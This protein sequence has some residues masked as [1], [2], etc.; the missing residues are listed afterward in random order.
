MPSARRAAIKK[1]IESLQYRV[2]YAEAVFN[3]L[4]VSGHQR[5]NVL[6]LEHEI[7]AIADKIVIVLESQSA[8]CELGA[9]AHPQLRKKLIVINDSNFRT[10]DSFV[11]TGP[12]AAMAEVKAPVLWYPMTSDG[13]TLLD[14]IGSTFND[15]KAAIFQRPAGGSARV[16]ENVSDLSATKASLYFVHD[17]VLF[18][19]PVKYDELITVLIAMFGKKPYDML[20]KLLGVLRSA[21]LV[22]VSEDIDKTRIYK[23]RS[24]QPYLNYNVDIRALTAAFRTYHLKHNANRFAN[25]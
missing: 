1:F 9:F 3:E 16:T 13:V 21:D 6:D 5:K 14:G 12:L 8:F 18:T 2:L 4:V 7:S 24:R 17:L 22:D 15:L 25:G 10:H 19:G 20:K 11:N 23:T